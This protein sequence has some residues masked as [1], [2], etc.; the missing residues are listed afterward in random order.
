MRR[1]LCAVARPATSLELATKLMAGST[2][3]AEK[4]NWEINMNTNTYTHTN[5]TLMTSVTLSTEIQL[6]VKY[7]PG[8]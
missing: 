8:W 3:G 6:N 1:A 4:Y 5:T 7:M 2:L